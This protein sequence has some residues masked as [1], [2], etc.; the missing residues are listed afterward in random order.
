MSANNYLYLSKRNGKYELHDVI[1][2]DLG[3]DYS[4]PP[5]M[6]YDTLEDAVLGAKC[7]MAK[8]EKD[9]FYYE[10]GLVLGDV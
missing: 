9:G 10:Y 6:S 2:A 7:Y 1:N 8:A 5:V 3:V 4:S